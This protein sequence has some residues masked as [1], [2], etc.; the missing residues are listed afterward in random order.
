MRSSR[1]ASAGNTRSERPEARVPIPDPNHWSRELA[2]HLRAHRWILASEAV[3]A[4]TK[5]AELLREWGAREIL[6]VGVNRGVGDEPR[7]KGFGQFIVGGPAVSGLQASIRAAEQ[8]F[9]SPPAELQAV[10]DEFDPD[11]T[12]LVLA[13]AFSGAGAYFGRPIFGAREPAWRALEDK[14]VI[15]R[16]FEEAGIKVAPH[17]IVPAR[18]DALLVAA[19]EVDRGEGTVW[20]GDAREG[21]HGGAEFTCWIRDDDDVEDALAR[22]APHCDSARVM[23]FLEGVPCSIHGWV[24]PDHVAAFRPC[25]MLVLRSARPPA[26]RYMSVATVWDPPS[27]DREAMRSIAR[28]MGAHL[29]DQYGYRGSF[30][31]DGV[32]TRDGFLP[33][34]INPRCGAAMPA[35][36]AGVPGFPTELLH[37]ASVERLPIDWRGRDLEELVVST[38]DA[39]RSAGFSCFGCRP[40]GTELQFALVRDPDWRLATEA[41]AALPQSK[42]SYG[43]ATFGG[44]LR[45]GFDPAQLAIGRSAAPMVAEVFAMLDRQLD[46]GVGTLAP[47]RDVRAGLGS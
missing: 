11:G 26:F 31:I 19:M 27:A 16:V 23:P 40:P 28:Q 38:A 20:A 41:D 14:V 13:A 8:I 36:M 42:G 44:M 29:R 6:C 15:D 4:S 39:C 18:R 32:M 33:T 2:P 24:L 47:A 12:A 10:V 1:T 22:L 3:A 30:S 35:L 7:D 25:E 46:L 21:F 45:V 17:R 43:R 5:R 37:F 34:E 9:T